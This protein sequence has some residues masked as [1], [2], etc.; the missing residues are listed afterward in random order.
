MANENDVAN[1]ARRIDEAHRP[2]APATVRNEAGKMIG[3]AGRVA[4]W[5]ENAA[6]QK[7]DA[8]TPQDS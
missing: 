8:E 5:P 3:D 1:R 4:Y 2:R 7:S 6:K